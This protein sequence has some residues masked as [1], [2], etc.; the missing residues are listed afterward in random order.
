PEPPPAGHS[1]YAASILDQPPPRAAAPGGVAR[2][3]AFAAT[4]Q[5]P[6]VPEPAV[7]PGPVRS[8]TPPLNRNSADWHAPVIRQKAEPAA[9]P[10]E[11]PKKSNVPLLVLLAIVLTV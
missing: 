2:P 5:T 8:P 10:V 11:T 6:A 3:T 7:V 9:D 1:P 4:L